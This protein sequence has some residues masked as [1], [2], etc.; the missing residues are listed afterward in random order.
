MGLGLLGRGLGDTVFL[1]KQGAEL[2][3]TD[4]KDKKELAPSLKK[5]KGFQ[6]ITYVLGEHRL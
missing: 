4:L 2:I 3:V 5:L 1:A 6:N